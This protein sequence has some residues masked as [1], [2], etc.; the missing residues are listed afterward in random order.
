MD[1]DADF[2]PTP[3]SITY[4]VVPLFINL[5]LILV[6]HRAL[7]TWPYGQSASEYIKT[8][9]HIAVY[10][11]LVMCLLKCWLLFK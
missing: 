9:S 10:H 6:A 5:L 11:S 2:K 3:P 8:S 1:A 7:P 4:E